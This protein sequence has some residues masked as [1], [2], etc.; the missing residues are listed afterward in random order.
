M[1][2]V[3]MAARVRAGSLDADD[4]ALVVDA[5]SA[6]AVGVASE[7]G[8]FIFRIEPANG[9]GLF[10]REQDAAVFRADET[11]GVV[12][13]LPDEF[14]LGAGGDHAGN[15]L[16]RDVLFGRGLREG[17]RLPAARCCATANPP[18]TRVDPRKQHAI[19]QMAFSFIISPAFS[20]RG[21]GLKPG[22]TGQRRA[23]AC[24]RLVPAAGSIYR[25]VFLG[26]RWRGCGA[27]MLSGGERCR[28][29]AR[30]Y[31]VPTKRKGRTVVRPLSA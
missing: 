23:G 8:K 15:L 3:G 28:A 16:H 25:G 4:A 18:R 14:P 13:A 21:S 27:V 29:E 9:A 10:L 22:A 6:G 17:L 24:S 7:N 19:V 11:I 30:R 1:A 12:R 20:M 26:E 31:K 5:Q 2:L